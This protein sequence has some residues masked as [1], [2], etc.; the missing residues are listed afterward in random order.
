MNIETKY[1][2]GQAVWFCGTVEAN[3]SGFE[4]YPGSIL[5]HLDINQ[6][7]AG[8]YSWQRGISGVMEG[9]LTPRDAESDKIYV[10][11]R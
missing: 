11:R 4:I 9:Y 10:L 3:I 6:K 5:Y 7:P 8:N 2:I 1:E